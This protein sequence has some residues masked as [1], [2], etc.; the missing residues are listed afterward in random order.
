MNPELTIQL[1]QAILTFLHRDT[2][3]TPQE[4][5]TFQAAV[6]WLKQQGQEAS[7]LLK[8]LKE[9]EEKN[10]KK[11]TVKRSAAKKKAA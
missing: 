2:K 10:A 1:I 4:I 8:Q 7:D 11:T 9:Q 6:G 5:E 3:L